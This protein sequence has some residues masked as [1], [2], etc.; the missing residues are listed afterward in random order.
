MNTNTIH[1]DP[2]FLRYREITHT[3]SFFSILGKTQKERYHS[4]FLGWLLNPA[5]T[6]GLGDAPLK[7]F[8]EAINNPAL[9]PMEHVDTINPS[10]L[11]GNYNF[12]NANVE[13]N[14]FSPQETNIAGVGEFDCFITGELTDETSFAIL[15]EQK[16]KS[17]FH[18]GQCRNYCN[19]LLKDER[20][21]IKV[22]VVLVPH[23]R[24]QENIVATCDDPKWCAITYDELF[25]Y[26]LSP[27]MQR[28]DLLP[29]TKIMLDDYVLALRT[30]VEGRS[31]IND[32]EL[33]KL[34]ASLSTKYPEEFR[35]IY[36]KQK[37]A[38]SQHEAI[39]PNKLYYIRI[40]LGNG[41]VVEFD[42]QRNEIYE[43]VV[44]LVADN[45]PLFEAAGRTLPAML[46]RSKSAGPSKRTF[47]SFNK[48]GIK[49]PVSARID[50]QR[51]LYMSAGINSQ[52]VNTKRTIATL[53]EMVGW[54]VTDF[55]PE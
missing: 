36:K 9:A 54:E 24:I 20:W 3:P 39:S 35:A 23:W 13:P 6:H 41:Q 34:V 16:T 2:E 22:P 5:G 37:A 46:K 28:N 7:L 12:S 4:G 52:P 45:F 33:Q 51:V 1:T 10:R 11:I 29:K 31:L 55:S 53:I 19:W 30:V 48:D 40:D 17:K 8:I 15:V 44:N 42:G 21:D 38:S 43:G 27:L 47:L 50:T 49:V 25:S 18:A 32:E 26:V 14:E